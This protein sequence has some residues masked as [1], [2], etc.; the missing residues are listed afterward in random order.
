MLFVLSAHFLA[1]ARKHAISTSFRGYE[2]HWSEIDNLPPQQGP[3]PAA[4]YA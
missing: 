1:R 4:I 2:E 3:L